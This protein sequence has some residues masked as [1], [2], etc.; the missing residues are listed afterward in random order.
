MSRKA[1][2]PTEEAVRARQALREY[3]MRRSLSVNK[4]ALESC[5]AQPV[6][7]RFLSGVTKS[8]TADV[9]RALSYA[10]IDVEKDIQRIV[11]G[12]ENARLKSALE[13]NL[14]GTEEVAEALARIIEAVG[15]VLR[16]F[17]AS[18]GGGT[19]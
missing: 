5:V 18:T 8:V 4:F 7:S 14:D 19:K 15:P 9:G 12:T 16:S 6:L 10:D 2:P 17:R 13:R 11:K 1:K 3:L